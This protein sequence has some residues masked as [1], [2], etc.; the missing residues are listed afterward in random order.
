MVNLNG[1]ESQ[2]A[3]GRRATV[4]RNT[5][6]RESTIDDL[7]GGRFREKRD[8]FPTR[9]STSNTSTCETTTRRPT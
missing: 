8:A 5:R 9:L 7:L 3:K 6:E 4:R 1:E 2:M